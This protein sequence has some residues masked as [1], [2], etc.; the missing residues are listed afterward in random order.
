MTNRLFAAA[1]LLLFAATAPA[2]QTAAPA[3][4]TKK[5]VPEAA[6][7]APPPQA[8]QKAQA[9]QKTYSIEGVTEYRL[10]NGLR[11]LAVP[12]PGSDTTTVHIAYLVGSRHE[13]YGEKGM[14]HLLEHLLFKGSKRHPNV[15]E[16]FNSRGARWNGTTSNDRTTYFETFAATAAN[17]DWALG[18]EAD[19]M[20]N[21]FVSKKDLDAEMTVVRNEFE[22]GENNAGSVLFQRMQ[23][24][25][26]PWHNYGNAIIGQRADIERVPIENLQAFYRTWYQPDN[27]LLIL[28]G[29]FDEKKALERVAHYFG[30]IPKPKRKLPSFYTEEPTQDGEREVTLRRVGENPIVSTLY[31]VPAGH[32][33]DYPAIDVLTNVLGDVPSGRLHRAL[34]QKGLAAHTW[35]AER[36]LHDP[37]FVYF[38]ASLPKD[39]KLDPAREALIATVEG[40]KGEPIRADEVERARTA[41]LNDF[42]KT[43]LDTGGYVRALSEFAAI[44]DWRLFFLYRERLKKV[45][46]ADVQ[47]VAEHYLKPAN[48]VLGTFIPTDAPD[49]ADIPPSQEWQAALDAFKGESQGV[50]LGEAFDPSPKNIESRVVRKN[51]SNGIQ[52]AL[53]PKTTRGGRVIATLTLH[54]GDEKSLTD[55]EVACSF[56]GGMLMRG[57]QKK[58]R[59]D[60]KDAFE[61]LNATVAVSGDGASIEVRRENLVPTLR[62][63]AEVLR[64]PAF[65]PAEFDEL[66]R[67]ALSGAE[68]QRTDPSA[69]ASLQLARHLSL[70]PKGHPNYTPDVEERI[71]W[72]RA[73]TLEDAVG[74]YRQLFGA[75]GAEFSAVGEFDPDELARVVG[76]LFGDWRT[77]SPFVRVPS[78][79]FDRPATEKEVLTPDKANAVLRAGINL[80]VRDDNADFPALVLANYLLGGSSTAR[81]PGR[82]REKE[83]L[84]YSTFSS[85]NASA[86]DEAGSFR[87]GAIFAPQNRSRVER[88]IREE[89]AR[90]V[91]DGFSAEEVSAG[92]QALLEQRRMARTQDRALA[93]RLSSYLFMKRTFAWDVDFE[94]KIAALTPAQVDAALRRHFDPAKLSLVTAGDFKQ[95]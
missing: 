56:A 48:R 25:A 9:P 30:A 51:L 45:A 35:G 21:S 88:A 19:R 57:T 60:I 92:K 1:F 59:A 7:K 75:T 71:E 33:P 16:E 43:Q 85:F 81:M 20:V 50:R 90:A 18:M 10:A 6:Q 32:H 80:K 2:Q 26:F 40:L 15:K 17:L 28:G 77:P 44:G 72:L 38:G 68:A 47:R 94:A 5:T 64:E 82:V 76:E 65:S 61:K 79:Y 86:F 27:A 87:I 53:L 42:E 36:G 13:G 83:G 22:M 95:K 55:R 14:A 73:A 63:V 3:Q 34:V 23:Q 78:R 62:L 58:S 91:R 54:W 69:Q 49:R 4:Q 12:D 67:A 37:G 84:S 74:C 89:L 52:A 93:N 8:L 46:L 11:V 66:K 31:R 24:L 41:L 70:Y 29:K 39:G